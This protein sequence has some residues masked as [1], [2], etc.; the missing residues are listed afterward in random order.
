MSLNQL[1]LSL[2]SK[3]SSSSSTNINP[4]CNNDYLIFEDYCIHIKTYGKL[5]LDIKK[6][7]FTFSAKGKMSD[8]F[9]NTYKNRT[10]FEILLSNIEIFQYINEIDKGKY[11]LSMEMKNKTHKVF[12]FEKEKKKNNEETWDK[13]V[14][15][16]NSSI[17]KNKEVGKNEK[18][19]PFFEFYSTEL[20]KMDEV[21]KKKICFL[22]KN[23]DLLI[24]YLRLSK[25]YD[26]ETIFQYIRNIR[27]EKI[28]INL[29]ENRIQLSRDE[30]L[31][32]QFHFYNKII[33]MNKLILSDIDMLNEKKLYYKD[34][35]KDGFQPEEFWNNFYSEQ[36]ENKT[37]IIGKYK[38]IYSH[39]ENN[40]EIND[41]NLFEE[42]EKNKYYYDNY[43]TN[44]LL[45]ENENDIKTDIKTLL[46]NYSINKMKEINYFSYTP[47]NLNIYKSINISKSPK[48]NLL[49]QDMEMEYYYENK[50]KNRNRI[51]KSELYKRISKMRKEYK[52]NT[53]IDKNNKNNTTIKAINE[54]VNKIYYLSNTLDKSSQSFMD[55]YEK[56]NLIRELS[57]ICD[58]ENNIYQKNKDI[59]SK[60]KRKEK[61]A[62]IKYIQNEMK[63]NLEKIKKEDNNYQQKTLFNFL[64]KYAEYITLN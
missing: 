51:P 10:E 16:I 30:E 44:Y 54:E 23:K 2:K 1:K 14:Y 48:M 24:L 40:F 47:Q 62:K 43:E 25:I 13:F 37:Y 45:K 61:K 21:T 35:I 55:L 41:N 28:D 26:P 22:M 36:K 49:S 5:T 64:I 32:I 27:P 38:P 52:K 53:I 11:K 60:Q 29:G 50:D 42:L 7:K 4:I 6:E 9:I 19:I 17:I 20:S 58:R 59:I 18:F 33:N 34:K 3:T 8:D 12:I 31:L 46:N 57:I 56:I 63:G 39:D 15:L